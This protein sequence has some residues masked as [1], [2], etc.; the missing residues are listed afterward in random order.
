[1]I[2]KATRATDED[3]RRTLYHEI[4]QQVARQVPYISLW[5]KTNVVVA[6]PGIAGVTLSPNADFG[7]LRDV[8]RGPQEAQR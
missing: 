4:Q 5:Y 2:D 7:L 1:L 3:E 8:T 6:Q